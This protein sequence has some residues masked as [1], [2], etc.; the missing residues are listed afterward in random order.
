MENNNMFGD[1]LDDD[2]IIDDM[3]EEIDEDIAVS[4]TMSVAKTSSK[5]APPAKPAADFSF[6]FSKLGIPG[7]I[8]GD[9]GL[10]VSRFAVDKTRFTVANKSLISIVSTQV[11]A[12]KCHY[13]EDLGS[14]L[15]FG[16]EC[17][18]RD[19]G[20]R[21]K[22]LFP[23]VVYDTDKNGRPVTSSI[24]NR[25]LAVGKG[26]YEDIMT[27]H[28]LSGDITTVDLLVTCKKEDY[29]E[30]SLQQAGQCRWKKSPTLTKEVSEFW[31][32]NMQHIFEAVARKMDAKTFAE[33]VGGKIDMGPSDS[34]VDFED[35]FK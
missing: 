22:Y 15:C 25:V 29:Q 23:V 17:C 34:D 16:G 18:E 19:G 27:I 24:E 8:S 6:D 11:I 31:S 3:S 33:K 9:I 1:Y 20:A 4:D 10:K 32:R 12:I 7:V 35:V 14:Y 5:S 28:D 26:T 21:I 2:I 30:I 13:N